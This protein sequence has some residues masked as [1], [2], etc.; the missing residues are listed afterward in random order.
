MLLSEIRLWVICPNVASLSPQ[1][2]SCQSSCHPLAFSCR[3][4]TF[5]RF[6]R[7]EGTSPTHASSA[8]LSCG[9]IFSVFMNLGSI[10]SSQGEGEA[11][12]TPRGLT[13][14]F[15]ALCEQQH[16]PSEALLSLERLLKHRTLQGIWFRLIS[17]SGN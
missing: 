7:S 5:E 12:R 16:G 11:H 10:V 3:M 6:T 15:G 14:D 4:C 2:G 13:A 1:L 8:P 9:G 17:D